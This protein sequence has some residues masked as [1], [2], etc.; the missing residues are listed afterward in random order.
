MSLFESKCPACGEIL[1]IDARR[2]ACG[3]TKEKKRDKHEIKWDHICQ[4]QYGALHCRYPV[5]QFMQGEHKG[6][7]I[8]HR[9]TP[10]GTMA[11]QIAQESQEA[12]REQY[13]AS[14]MLHTYGRGD[15]PAVA[16]LRA[17][18]RL[19]PGNLTLPMREPGE[20]G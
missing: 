11:A 13:L 17:Q 20:D 18:L 3:W 6:L 14:A 1:N 12:T 2:C 7:C 19:K 16:R 15:N 10:S 4:W 5:G 8:F 9:A